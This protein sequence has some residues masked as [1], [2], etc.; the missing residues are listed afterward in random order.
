M[1]VQLFHFLSFTIITNVILSNSNN[2]VIE[3]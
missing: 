3:G 1:I 2:K